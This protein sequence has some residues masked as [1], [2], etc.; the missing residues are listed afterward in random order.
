MKKYRSTCQNE[1]MGSEAV[2]WSL[3]RGRVAAHAHFSSKGKGALWI[4]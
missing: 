4:M 2:L 3:L 1:G